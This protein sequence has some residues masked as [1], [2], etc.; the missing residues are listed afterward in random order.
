MTATYRI[1]LV[2]NMPRRHLGVQDDL[3][4]AR[5][6]GVENPG[7]QMVKS[8]D[9]VEMLLHH[10]I[11]LLADYGNLN[12]TPPQYSALDTGQIQSL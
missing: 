11:P 6:T 2:M 4:N 12:A 9:R 1:G 5:E 7:L 3:L 10:V 8:D